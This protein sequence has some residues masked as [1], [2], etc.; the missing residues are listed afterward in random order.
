M[1]KEDFVNDLKATK[2]MAQFLK[3]C[4]EYY[5][6]ENAEPGTIQKIALINNIE[7]VLKLAN[8]KP[9]N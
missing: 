3:V 4:G 1:N 8:A 9:K 2:T 6:L 7:T 5:D